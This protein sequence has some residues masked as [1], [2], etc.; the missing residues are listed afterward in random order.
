MHYFQTIFLEEAEKF[1]S[2][3]DSKAVRKVFYNIERALKIREKYFANK[4]KK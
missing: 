2:Q 4:F 3:L 1:I